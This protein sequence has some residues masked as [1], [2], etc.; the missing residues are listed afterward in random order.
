[1]TGTGCLHHKKKERF[2]MRDYLC[3]EDDLNDTIKFHIEQ[4]PKKMEKIASLQEDIKNGVQKYPR[5][6]EDIIVDAKHD[7]FR[8]IYELIRAEYSLGLDCG[9]LEKYYIQGIDILSDIGLYKKM[10]M[11]IRYSI[12]H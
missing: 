11:L 5:K 2:T 3:K 1:M 7:T 8:L 10:D 6:N 9:E 12:F 4:I